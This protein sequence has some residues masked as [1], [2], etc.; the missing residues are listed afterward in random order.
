MLKKVVNSVDI[1]L[2]EYSAVLDRVV[3][4]R[5]RCEID[6]HIAFWKI[7]DI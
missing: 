5:F 1:G 2:E 3:H 7:C 6:Q 4:E